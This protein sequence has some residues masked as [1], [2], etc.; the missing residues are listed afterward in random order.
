LKKAV[1]RDTWK[2]I[3]TDAWKDDPRGAQR[4]YLK[5]PSV[6]AY[7]K[8]SRRDTW[9]DIPRGL[10]RKFLKKERRRDT[11]KERQRDLLDPRD[12]LREEPR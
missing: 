1:L 5:D 9:K 11:W 12:V 6:R 2:E 8:A 10:L 3:Q 4:E 7:L